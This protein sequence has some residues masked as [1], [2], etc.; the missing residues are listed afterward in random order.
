MS[1]FILIKE[2][3]A[4]TDQTPSTAGFVRELRSALRNRGVLKQE[5]DFLVFQQDYRFSSPSTAVSV[6][7]GGSANGRI[8]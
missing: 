7:V 2:S 5:N 4:R 3:K 1:G 6:L 8:L